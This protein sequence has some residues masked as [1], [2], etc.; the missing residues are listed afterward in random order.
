MLEPAPR[1]HFHAKSCFSTNEKR[2]GVDFKLRTPPAK[3][4]GPRR[5]RQA[6]PSLPSGDQRVRGEKDKRGFAEQRRIAAVVCSPRRVYL[7]RMWLPE[8]SFELWVTWGLGAYLPSWP[9][10]DCWGCAQKA[11]SC[12]LLILHEGEHVW[13]GFQA[14]ETRSKAAGPREPEAAQTL[15]ALWRPEG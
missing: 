4:Q 6:R 11:F 3:Q 8:W 12:Q 7:S 5:Q 13:S 1:S 9:R 14:H 10:G 15:F 2:F